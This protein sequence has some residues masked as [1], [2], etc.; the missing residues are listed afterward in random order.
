M[1]NPHNING[2]SPAEAWNF[3]IDVYI[4]PFIPS[5]KIL[6]RLPTCISRFLGHRNEAREGELDIVVWTWAF[7]GA[8]A[9]VAVVEAV[10]LHWSYFAEKGCPMIVGSY[11]A[12]AILLYSAV[13]SPLAQPRNAF[14]GQ[15]LSA[16]TGVTITKLFLLSDRFDSLVWLAGALACASSSLVMSITKT[17][18]PPAGATALLAAVDPGVRGM[19]WD[20]IPVV[21][22]SSALMIAVACLVDN[23]QRSYP[24]YWW[25]PGPVGKEAR[26]KDRKA[27]GKDVEKGKVDTAG[28]EVVVG[29]EG[30]VLPEFLVLGE[31]EKEVLMQIKSRIANFSDGGES[32]S[33]SL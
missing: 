14:F 3:D 6:R 29:A 8:F 26:S 11:G 2:L 9:G 33:S 16:A 32:E 15:V 31:V 28:M 12:A 17:I 13:D 30:I 20:L 1:K 4:S 19:G 7:V 25:T 21:I 23:L 5:P 18:H 27:D 22:I 10:F 24:R